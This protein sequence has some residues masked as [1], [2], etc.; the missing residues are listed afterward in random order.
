[1]KDSGDPA[2]L[3]FLHLPKTGGRTL[4]MV[5]RRHFGSDRVF[6]VYAPQPAQALERYDGLSEQ[7]KREYRAI[8]GHAPMDMHRKVPGPC[9]CV[10]LL[11]HPVDR[12][13]STYYFARRTESHPGYAPIHE[14]DMSLGETVES[15]V[16]PMLDNGQT[17]VLGE[18]WGE[19]GTC[20][21]EAADRAMENIDSHVAMAGLTERYDESLL[22][23]ARTFG[24]PWWSM[25]YVRRNVAPNRPP[26]AEIPRDVLSR[27]EEL[28]QV[29]LD[30]YRRITER[31]DQEIA[32]A[33]TRFS[34]EA[35]AFQ[36]A[37]RVYPH[38]RALRSK[39][40]RLLDSVRSR[41]A[42]R[43]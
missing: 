29:D 9:V 15:G 38:Y 37:N 16:I 18:W 30:L 10:T 40:G 19:Y 11:R 34:A 24:W 3:I 7:E 26:A 13:V 42:V 1:M 8:V 22:L 17:R 36:G 4:E 25:L 6:G 31:F 14:Q 33:G 43:L 27:I 21:P 28:N 41:A 20:P 32:A 23:M 2:T 5:I 39:T 12:V 35:R